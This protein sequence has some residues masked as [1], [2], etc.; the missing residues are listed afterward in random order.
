MSDRYK[1]LASG[2]FSLLLGMGVARFAYTP[3]LPQMQEQ[4]GLGLAE[5]GWLAAIN[6]VGYLSG[7]V[8]AS[9]ISDPALRNRL[10]RVGMVVAVLTTAMMGITTDPT[11]WAVSRYLAGLSTATASLLGTGL[12]LN[13]L[14]VHDHR[15][16]LGIPFAGIGLGIAGSA[17]AV[18]LMN[19]WGLDWREQWYAFTAIGFV[20]LVPALRWMPA[21]ER[22]TVTRSGHSMQDAPPSPAFL[23]LL[24][25]AYFCAG[26]GYVVSATFIVA[27]VDRLPGV[28]GHG[29][30]VFLFIGLGAAPAS[31]ISDLVARRMGE[32]NALILAAV[33][34][35]A[36]I[37]L[38]VLG[39]G[40]LPALLGAALFGATVMG[41]VSL[42]LTM[43]GRCYP[44]S[45]ARMMGKMTLSYGIAQVIAPAVTGS[46]ATHL[47]SY[48]DGLYLATVVMAIGAL[49]LVLLR[50]VEG[51]TREGI[52]ARAS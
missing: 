3:L 30:L 24:M 44:T 1:V 11:V 47:G 27:I 12:I 33:L 40:L 31:V 28:A 4:A 5:A 15:G 20:L 26:V 34:Q 9:L 36:G 38:P 32:V 50:V 52:E 18:A 10:Y 23:R 14:I 17:A 45:P 43:A 13:W 49:L 37:L 21:P 8:V 6:Y 46:L 2:A 41:I 51:R 7:A 25:A 35:I 19:R 16:E 29:T 39:N 42:V 48:R 22:G